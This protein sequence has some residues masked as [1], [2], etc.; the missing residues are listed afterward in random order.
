MI[1]GQLLLN[2]HPF[3]VETGLPGCEHIGMFVNRRLNC[4]L[5]VLKKVN[6]RFVLLN[7]LLLRTEVLLEQLVSQFT[8]LADLLGLLANQL[9]SLLV[10]PHDFFQTF[11]PVFLRKFWRV[12]LSF[13]NF[14]FA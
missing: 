1:L 13:F 10:H 12:N 3:E 9:F 6:F 11:G 5:R 2:L 4:F 8:D 7:T 14:E